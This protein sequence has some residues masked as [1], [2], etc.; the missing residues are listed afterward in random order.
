MKKS[1]KIWLTTATI[2]S[3]AGIIMFAVVMAAG[4][5][6]AMKLNG[7][8]DIGIERVNLLDL[9]WE[10]GVC[11][12][13]KSRYFFHTE[14]CDRE[15]IEARYPETAERLKGNTFVSAKFLYDENVDVADK[16]TED[17][18]PP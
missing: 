9:Y 12:I 15:I 18:V 10:P 5:W 4:G 14:L 6:D 11:D 16:V 3:L 7:L 17:K 2:L 8:G 13:Q 1:T